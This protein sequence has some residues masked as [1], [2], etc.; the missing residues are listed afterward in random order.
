MFYREMTVFNIQ[1]CNISVLVYLGSF[2][3]QGLI[4]AFQIFDD[5]GIAII[6]SHIACHYFIY[7]FITL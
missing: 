7:L 3:F 1:I 4:V 2:V 5:N 6:G